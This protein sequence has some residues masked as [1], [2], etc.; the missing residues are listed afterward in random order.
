MALEKHYDREGDVLY[1]SVKKSPFSHATKERDGLLVDVDQATN[2]VVG[3]TV[4][5]Y[6]AKFR[7]LPDLSWLRSLCLPKSL[8]D[9]LLE[10]SAV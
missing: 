5:D 7:K 2:E 9:F 6:E 1:L 10:R 3:I 4:L 8:S